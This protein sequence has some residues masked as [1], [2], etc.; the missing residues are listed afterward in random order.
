MS[1]SLGA[2]KNEGRAVGRS[3][4]KILF[5]DRKAQTEREAEKQRDRHKTH[6]HREREGWMLML[7]S[8]ASPQNWELAGWCWLLG[9]NWDCDCN[10]NWR[11]RSGSRSSR[12]E[13]CLARALRCH[14]IAADDWPSALAME[15]QLAGSWA[16]SSRWH[17]RAPACSISSSTAGCP[18]QKGAHY[19]YT[20]YVY[21]DGTDWVFPRA[22]QKSSNSK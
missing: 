19:S 16:A 20:Y 22:P 21:Y 7:D 3:N 13:R 6:R 12:K 15:R 18:N 1:I 4:N 10:W 9:V 17:T 5:V 14:L 2:D 11:Q 8:A